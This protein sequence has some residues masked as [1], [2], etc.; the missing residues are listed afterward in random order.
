M[1]LQFNHL[2]K[3]QSTWKDENKA[4]VVSAPKGRKWEHQHGPR[5]EVIRTNGRSPRGDRT[6]RIK[7]SNLHLRTQRNLKNAASKFQYCEYT[8]FPVDSEN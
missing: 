1:P 3:D 2:S 8:A 4:D 6:K 5:D 7:S